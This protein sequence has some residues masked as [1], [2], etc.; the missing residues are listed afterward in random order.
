MLT[1]SFISALYSYMEGLEYLSSQI[2]MGSVLP[3]SEILDFYRTITQGSPE[4]LHLI[5]SYENVNG[6][7]RWV[8]MFLLKTDR[9]LV[10]LTRR[11]DPVREILKICASL[12]CFL[13]IILPSPISIQQILWRGG[14]QLCQGNSGY[15]AVKQLWKNASSIHRKS[16]GDRGGLGH[17]LH[18]ISKLEADLEE[19]EDGDGVKT[20]SWILKEITVT[21]VEQLREKIG[22]VVIRGYNFSKFYI[23]D[24]LLND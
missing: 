17:Y 11:C 15:Y 12:K 8:Y 20:P 24:F 3:G 18:M 23:Q 21:Q 1:A 16:I 13:D 14:G 10:V 7:N 22:N 2:Q 5:V 4:V 9:K 19:D 6:P